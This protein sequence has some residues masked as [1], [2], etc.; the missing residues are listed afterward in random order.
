M[1]WPA[2]CARVALMD[3]AGGAA[4][5]LL[6]QRRIRCGHCARTLP[7]GEEERALDLFE[8][9]LD[10]AATWRDLLVR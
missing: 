8:P 6:L 4:A 3:D 5:T 9:S 7:E 1:Q 2:L 10:E